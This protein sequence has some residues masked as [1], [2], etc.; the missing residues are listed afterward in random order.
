MKTKILLLAI[1][2]LA[3]SLR[4]YQISTNPPSLYWDEASLAWNSNAIL[5]TGSDEFGVPHPLTLRSFNDYKPG[6][7]VYAMMPAIKLF[8]LN[9]FAVRLPS[10]L[11]GSILPLLLYILVVRVS[12]QKKLALLAAFIT[13][14]NPWMIQF[15]RGAFEANL[16][17]AILILGI[18]IFMRFYKN[19]LGLVIGEI[20][21]LSSV[22][23]YHANKFVAPL[24][25]LIFLMFLFMKKKINLGKC[26]V[27]IITGAVMLL[28]FAVSLIRGYGLV[29]L[30]ATSGNINFPSFITAW[31]SH[32]N[33]DFLFLSADGNA[34]HHVTGF[35]L[36]YVFESILMFLGILDYIKSRRHI[37]IFF[38]L[39]VLSLMPAAIAKDAPHAI[40]SIL[41]FPFFLILV[42]YGFKDVM[43]K[44]VYKI[45]VL[46]L[47]AYFI[48]F[49][50]NSRFVHYPAETSQ[51]W[52]YGYRQVA[53]YLFK[54]NNYAKY[55]KIVVTSAYDQPYIYMLLF[56]RDKFISLK[57]DGMMNAGFDK[58]LFKKINWDEEKNK[59]NT[60]LI[61]TG[62][63]LET[64]T[65]VLQTIYFLD[66]KVAFKIVKI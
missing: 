59:K 12:H 50:A 52:Q 34:R 28:P 29:R 18:V 65:N 24:A 3:L 2:L 6:L 55:N 66:G 21:I 54:E 13:S 17:L 58:F 25:L 39:F 42:V 30:N 38:T 49:Y 41:A 4:G 64:N 62:D 40:R 47:Y 27:V 57:N 51:N 22:Y 20:I 56:S 7:Y 19:L 14:V 16:G 11:V 36:F 9:E 44:K 43:K 53:D 61:G 63:E 8:G 48:F 1:F 26:L 10:V 5:K 31:F 35:G 15:S 23:A 37:F 45:A 32:F 46:T 60:L 33:F